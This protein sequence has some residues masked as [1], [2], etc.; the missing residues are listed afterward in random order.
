MRGVPRRSGKRRVIA[1]AAA[2]LTVAGALAVAPAVLGEP[3]AL[4]APAEDQAWKL[5]WSDEFDGAAGSAPDASKWVH[6]LGAKGEDGNTDGW[7]NNEL[8]TYTN[9][10][11]N[12][13]LDGDGNLYIRPQLNNDDALQCP[14]TL[15]N[16]NPRKLGAGTCQFTSA[17]LKTKGKFS[18]EGGRFE[19]RVKVAEGV[20]AWPSFWAMGDDRGWP[21]RG[22][23]DIFENAGAEPGHISGT[24]HSSDQVDAYAK[25]GV[26]GGYDL[27]DGKKFGDD[28]HVFAVD[29]SPEQMSFS[30][31]G[32]VYFTTR[33]ADVLKERADGWKF[34]QPF[35]LLLN[36]AIDS[37]SWRPANQANPDGPAPTQMTV[38]Y[39]RVYSATGDGEGGGADDS[40]TSPSASG[41]TTATK[42]TKSPAKTTAKTTKPSNKASGTGSPPPTTPPG[43]KCPNANIEYSVDDGKTWS[44]NG[45]LDSFHDTVDVRLADATTKKSCSYKVSLAV[46]Q[47]EGKTWA[48]SG[49]QKF[50]GWDTV[51]LDGKKATAKLDVGKYKADCFVQLDL[52]GNG[53]KFDGTNEKNPLPHYPDAPY[54]ANL[55]A[56]WNGAAAECATPGGTTPTESAPP[57]SSTPSASASP[58]ASASASA[59]ATP[60]E[61]P[62][63]TASDSPSPSA[64]ASASAAPVTP[65]DTTTLTN[66]DGSP[67]VNTSSDVPGNLAATGSS[68]R[69]PV[70]AGTSAVM[71]LAGTALFILTRRRE[72][73]P[74]GP[75]PW[76]GNPWVTK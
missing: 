32:K 54:P 57:V 65:D 44:T 46:Y 43:T 7:G 56:A 26:G 6:D 49:T 71:V 45:R 52:Y 2:G 14:V 30:V 9:S 21:Q 35:Y 27:P 48:T 67:P 64:S 13:G 70:I 53:R 16:T 61:S 66:D 63:S 38:D 15:V 39:V 22:E 73:D 68:S 37:G 42:A 47:T 55:I 33:K 28:F 31:D 3:A 23:I 72:P 62:S 58:T 75:N 50:L 59:S 11:K 41:T 60:S 29:W 24:T 76:L 40:T 5:T 18:Q 4:R 25:T 10:R 19:A 8:Q 36:V 34:D 51:T 20:G 74:L 69:L 1:V 12:S 17:R